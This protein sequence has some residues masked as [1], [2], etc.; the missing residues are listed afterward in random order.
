MTRAEYLLE[1]AVDEGI[2]DKAADA[3]GRNVSDRVKKAAGSANTR[4]THKAV[5]A[6]TV[7]SL[8]YHTTRAVMKG[9]TRRRHKAGK[10]MKAYRA[11]KRGIKK[12]TKMFSKERS[13]KLDDLEKKTHKKLTQ[14]V[15]DT[16]A[17]KGREARSHRSAKRTANRIL[18]GTVSGGRSL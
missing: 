11:E 9:V 13:S 6:L 18:Y 3:V 10:L 2:M 12:D 1:L 8:D 15:K 5:R 7:P 14:H 17:A 4:G 16:R